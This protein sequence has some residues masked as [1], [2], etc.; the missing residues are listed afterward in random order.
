M[1]V[2]RKTRDLFSFPRRQKASADRLSP[3]ANRKGELFLVPPWLA[4]KGLRLVTGIDVSTEASH[5]LPDSCPFLSILFP[6]HGRK[7]LKLMLS[8]CKQ[9]D[10]WPSRFQC[11]LRC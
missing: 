3:A 7:T 4:L 5:S 10:I 11:Q 6:L 8:I 9:E 2:R 1:C